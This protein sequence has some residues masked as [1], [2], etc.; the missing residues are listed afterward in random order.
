MKTTFFNKSNISNENIHRI[1]VLLHS[2]KYEHRGR[3]MIA[4]VA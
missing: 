1:Y 3:W 4:F 2:V